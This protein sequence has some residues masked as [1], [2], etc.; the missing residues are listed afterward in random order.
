M[1]QQLEL[2][3][4]LGRHVDRTDKPK[5]TTKTEEPKQTLGERCVICGNVF[6]KRHPIECR[7]ICY[8]CADAL[9]TLIGGQNEQSDNM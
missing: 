5:R 3:N 7:C 2:T 1:S 9:R 8:K 4:A 6:A